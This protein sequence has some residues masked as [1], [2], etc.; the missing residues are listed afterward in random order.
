MGDALAHQQIEVLLESVPTSGRVLLSIVAVPVGRDLDAETER[1]ELADLGRRDQ[2]DL[3]KLGAGDGALAVRTD[4]RVLLRHRAGRA[5]AR[6]LVGS[7][8]FRRHAVFG[9]AI[10]NGGLLGIVGSLE[11]LAP[12]LLGVVE[13]DAREDLDRLHFAVLIR[14]EQLGLLPGEADLPHLALERERIDARLGG[15]V[16]FGLSRRDV[17][18]NCAAVK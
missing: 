16:R 13:N 5:G 12:A 15:D 18:G 2:G 4:V 1:R 10:G 9:P 3:A 17:G 11:I 6:L 7:R 14:L 8:R